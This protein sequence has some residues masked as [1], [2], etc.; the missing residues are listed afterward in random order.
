MAATKSKTWSEKFS[1]ARRRMK[2]KVY[3]FA[4]R[5]DSSKDTE[6]FA[7]DDHRCVWAPAWCCQLKRHCN[8]RCRLEAA[9]A[10]LRE[11]KVHITEFLEGMHMFTATSQELCSDLRS[12]TA[13]HSAA[14]VQLVHGTGDGVRAL[15]KLNADMDA[16]IT[17]QMN[18]KLAV[19]RSCERVMT[20]RLLRPIAGLLGNV[21]TV[22]HLLE[23]RRRYQTDVDAYKRK[24]R[25]LHDAHASLRAAGTRLR[26][27]LCSLTLRER[28]PAKREAPATTVK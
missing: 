6:A 17:T 12:K 21:D 13:R 11:M 22:R 26:L 3:E 28:R 5:A 1:S 15:S 18:L 14:S 7:R 4:G 25:Y 19:Y 8:A 27:P 23:K 20:E 10:S 9:V 16:Y 2:Q 24:V